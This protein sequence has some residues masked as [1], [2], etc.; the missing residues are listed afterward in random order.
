[1]GLKAIF[2]EGP[3]VRRVLVEG[4]IFKFEI[5]AKIPGKGSCL[6]IVLLMFNIL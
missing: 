5:G 2:E 1:M 6:Y 3:K 4:H